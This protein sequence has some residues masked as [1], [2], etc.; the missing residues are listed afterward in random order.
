[1]TG[2]ACDKH[3][4]VVD[5]AFGCL[6]ANYFCPSSLHIALITVCIEDTHASRVEIFV[7]KL[8]CI[9]HNVNGKTR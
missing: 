9:A 4:S 3:I 7:S 5:G 1:M 6:S 8:I 2:T